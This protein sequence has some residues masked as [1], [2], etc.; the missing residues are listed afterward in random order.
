MRALSHAVNRSIENQLLSR[1]LTKAMIG[2]LVT[3]SGITSYKTTGS[4][5]RHVMIVILAAV[6]L[7][8]T[9]FLI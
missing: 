2:G 3:I 9:I 8:T 4:I 6:A 5:N 7:I 1:K